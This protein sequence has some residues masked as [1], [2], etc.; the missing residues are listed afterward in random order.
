ML[1]KQSS[2]KDP[3]DWF[4]SA[5]DRLKIADLA[6]AKEGLTQSGI[7]LLQEAVER[8][9]KGYLAAKG[10]PLKRTH[11]LDVLLIEAVRLD[12]RFDQ[13]RGLADELTRDFFA[14]HYPGGDWTDVGKNYAALRQQAEGLIGLI[15]SDMPQ[16]FSAADKK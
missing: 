6:W 11:D 16:Y 4:Y 2:D 15:R 10:Q 3:S 12:T 8:Y 7:E 14:Q 5:A 13:F 9:L 1:R